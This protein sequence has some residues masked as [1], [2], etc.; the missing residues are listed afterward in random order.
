MREWLGTLSTETNA[1]RDPLRIV[2]VIGNKESH[3]GTVEVP[4]SCDLV[5]KYSFSETNG[6]FDL[7]INGRQETSGCWPA[8]NGNCLLPFDQGNLKPGTNTI[9]VW[10]M[11]Q[12]PS[13][14]D[15]FLWATGPTTQVVLGDDRT[16]ER[17]T[18][19]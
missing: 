3:V 6:K 18:S 16:L 12:N 5:K 10:F 19:R 14:I 7:I 15:H 1:A 9:Q 17:P 11:I 13:D 2:Q 8:T 4:L